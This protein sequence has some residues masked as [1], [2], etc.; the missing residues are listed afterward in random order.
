MKRQLRW[1]GNQLITDETICGLVQH[2]ESGLYQSRLLLRDSFFS[3]EKEAREY[4][5]EITKA[6]LTT[7][8]KRLKLI[9]NEQV[10]E[11]KK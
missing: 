3:K 6:I 2:N 1:S 11:S 9:D 4:L 8:S 7:R 5:E 10:E